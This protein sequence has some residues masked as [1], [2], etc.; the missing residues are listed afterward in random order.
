[1][2]KCELERIVESSEIDAFCLGV[3]T[4]KVGAA[5]RVRRKVAP[6]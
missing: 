2:Q 3:L 5:L 6:I 1:M 4:E